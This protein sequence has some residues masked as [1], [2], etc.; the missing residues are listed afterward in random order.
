MALPVVRG[1]TLVPPT[2]LP[3]KMKSIFPFKLFNAMQSKS[4]D[5]VYR[6]SD[7]FVLSSPTGSGKTVIL[8]LAICRLLTISPNLDFKLVYQAPTKALCAERYRDWSKKFGPFGLNCVEFTGDTDNLRVRPQSAH[9]I[10][11][12]PEKWDSI[13]RK[14]KDHRR[15]MQVVK[16]FLI[17]EVHILKEDRGA[18]LE[19]VVS[20]MK[21]IGSDVRF[22]ALSATVPNSDDI[23]KWLGKSR[24]E[25]HLP[26]LREVFDETYR[27][28]QVE[29]HVYGFPGYNSNEFSFD[30]SLNSQSVPLG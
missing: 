22:V 18:G 29:R 21:S 20:R 8:E 3:D 11:T 19:A 7:N 13:T 25:P 17:D 30:K 2:S 23:A 24:D 6:S 27:P 10:I 15:F 9:V 5:S 14:W 16:L 12:T 1:I 26:A 28:I 4:F